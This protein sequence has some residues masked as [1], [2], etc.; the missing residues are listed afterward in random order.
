M[1]K[2]M[3]RR[4]VWGYTLA[5]ILIMVFST[6]AGM[7][8][9]NYLTNTAMERSL[10]PELEAE[11]VEALPV[12]REWR[13]NPAVRQSSITHFEAYELAFTVMEYWFDAEQNLVMA[14]GILDVSRMLMDEILEWDHPDDEI[15]FMDT[16]DEP[17]GKE[18]HFIVMSNNVYDDDGSLLGKV[19]VGTNMTPLMIIN[20]Q[21]SWSA[22]V[23]IVMVSVLAFIVGNY[24]AGKAI[25]PI[26]VTMEKQ[27][28]FVAD[29]S[30]ELRTPLAV[31][32][33]SVDL[34]KTDVENQNIAAGM[35]D[36]ILHMRRLVD[37][38]LVLARSD[39]DKNEQIFAH[40]D[41]SDTAETAM[42]N[43]QTLAQTKN[44]RLESCMESGVLYYG[45]EL[46]I[47]QLVNILLDN[48]IKYSP[49][50]TVVQIGLTRKHG[51]VEISF[52]DHG[53][54]IPPKDLQNI[55]ERFYRIDKARS[56]AQGGFGLGLA[57]A[58]LIV[59]AHKGEISVS[60]TVG[61]GSTF[62]VSLPLAKA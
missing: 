11:I 28:N 24:F 3:H 58:K 55:F 61:Q 38:L 21:Y 7:A 16:Y 17:T 50:N 31:L 47:R 45:D 52:K 14:E 30:H 41:L 35:K 29:A 39:N 37:S 56:R 20:R 15:I 40:F 44:I 62:R 49:D 48:A 13:D 19:I 27:K 1:I 33:A 10:Y 46:K 22:M 9:L 57:I 8:A 51:Y 25:K 5:I 18:W 2:R 23:I 53:V 43:M 26:A 59:T 36:E 12:L 6:L 32:L 60:S 54:G 34:L 42:R 4:L